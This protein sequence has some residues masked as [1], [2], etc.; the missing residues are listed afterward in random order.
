MTLYTSVSRQGGLSAEPTALLNRF[1]SNAAVNGATYSLPAAEILFCCLNGHVPEEELDLLEL[2][3]RGVAKARAS[4]AKIMRC[5]FLDSGLLG[6]ILHHVPD[7]PLRHA[8]TPGFSSTADA[9]EQSAFPYIR[10]GQP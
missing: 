4:P 7:N 9:P 5:Q 1:D 2:A 10:G 3:A 6:A 8:V